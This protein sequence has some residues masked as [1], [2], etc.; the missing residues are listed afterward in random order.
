MAVAID[1]GRMRK[2]TFA[3]IL[4]NILSTQMRAT[5]TAARLVGSTHAP[6]LTM[7]ATGMVARFRAQVTSMALK[8]V[9]MLL[10][11]AYAPAAAHMPVRPTI[12]TLGPVSNREAYQNTA[13]A[14]TTNK[15][16]KAL[17]RSR[18]SCPNHAPNKI[19]SNGARL[20]SV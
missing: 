6:R 11:R 20:K 9:G 7:R 10:R 17:F 15:I 16:V 2:E 19:T 1:S 18:A 4:L 5:K 14:R 12:Q 8:M 3:R 13:L